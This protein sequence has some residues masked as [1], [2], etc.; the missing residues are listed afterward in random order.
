VDGP[1]IVQAL[2]KLL[3]NAIKFSSRDGE[4][5]L[6]ARAI[7]AE[8]ALFEVQD[9]GQGIAETAKLLKVSAAQVGEVRRMAQLRRCL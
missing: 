4:I 2:T 1:R 6:R 8:Q 9:E 3:S 5:W 7:S